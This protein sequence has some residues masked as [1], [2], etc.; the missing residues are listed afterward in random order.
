MPDLEVPG[1][2]PETAAGWRAQQARWTKGHA[3]CA[4]K[5]LPKI[6]TSKLPLARKAVLS[7]QICQFAFYTLALTS[8][9]ISLTL[10]AMGVVYIQSIAILGLAVTAFGLSQVW[11][12]SIWAR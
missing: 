6:W 10:M 2:L 9:V 11:A 8:A 1:E 5:L 4:K 12:I 7:L 3:Q